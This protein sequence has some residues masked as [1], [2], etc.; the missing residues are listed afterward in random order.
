MEPW[1]LWKCPLCCVVSH[2][3]LG[4]LGARRVAEDW[5]FGVASLSITQ[6]LRGLKIQACH[7]KI[8]YF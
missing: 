8:G 1:C 4:A 7:F 2:L 5:H 3:E 6:V